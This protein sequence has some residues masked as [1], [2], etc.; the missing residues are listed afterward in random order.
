MRP[1]PDRYRLDDE[2]LLEDERTGLDEELETTGDDELETTGLEELETTGLDELET[3][4]LEELELGDFDDLLDLECEDLLGGMEPS[5]WAI[6]VAR[7]L[8]LWS[9]GFGRRKSFAEAGRR[10]DAGPP[11]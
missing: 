8:R 7:T 1:R 3:T 4:G 5:L 2:L 10:P 6:D 11:F 9:A